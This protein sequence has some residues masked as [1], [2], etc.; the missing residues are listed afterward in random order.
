MYVIDETT[1]SGEAG[2][3]LRPGINE[4]I[5]LTSVR[6]DKAGKKDDSPFALIFTFEN[7]TGGSF[8]EKLFE[9]N[10]EKQKEFAV[11]SPRKHGRDDKAKG[12]VKGAPITPDQAVAIAY[13]DQA[14]RIKHIMN[15][16]IPEDQ[17]K[18]SA[19]SFQEYAEAI[20]K[21]LRGKTDVLLRLK[22]TLNQKDYYQIPK[23]PPFLERMDVNP[24][25][26]EINPAYDRIVKVTP[27]AE[28]AELL[29]S[30]NST[31]ELDSL[32]HSTLAGA[33]PESAPIDDLPF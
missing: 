5:K 4:N 17:I 12:Y 25:K 28:K 16:F 7:E 6:Y 18:I 32:A 10:P 3:G 1:S 14:S 20:G 13:A 27:D 21:L 2:S 30:D 11:T 23:F 19:R 8:E 33:F 24:S 15:K 29:P 26:L 22:I 31:D 9:I